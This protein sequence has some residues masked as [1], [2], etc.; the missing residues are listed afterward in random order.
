[1]L[2]H[3]T[4][5]NYALIDRLELDWNPGFTAITGET[6]AGKSIL[7]GALG[8]IVGDRA[9]TA[10]AKNKAEKVVVEA[11]FNAQGK[12]FERFFSAH[13][14][15][16]E[17]VGIVRREI[18]PSGK[19]RA[20]INDTPVKLSALK[21]LGALLVDIHGQHQTMLLRDA[22]FQLR[23][24]DHFAGNRDKAKAYA[25]V[26]AEYS[27]DKRRKAELEKAEAD[28]RAEEDFV[29]FQYNELA[30]AQL[31]DT[32]LQILEEELRTL[33]H[34][35]EIKRELYV[36]TGILSEGDTNVL[37]MLKQAESVLRSQGRYS[38]AVNNLAGR[39]TESL[40]ELTDIH[41]EIQDLGERIEV[42]P[43]R[44]QTVTER[45]DAV[46]RLLIKHRVAHVEELIA[47]RDDLESKL[48]GYGTLE[49]D[50]ESCAKKLLKLQES[51]EERAA[52]LHKTRMAHASAFKAAV[53]EILVDLGMS[54]AV[55]EVAI[56]DAEAY[57]SNGKDDVEFNFSANAGILPGPLHK[58]ASGGEMSRCMLALKTILSSKSGLP[59]II[60]D[61]IDT[62][63]SGKVASKLSK[64]LK[65]MSDGMQVICITHLPQ[66]AAR[67]DEHLRVEKREEEGISVT[68]LRV[69]TEDERVE[70]LAN[71]LSGEERS[72]AAL[73]NAK[74]LLKNN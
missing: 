71:M 22:D 24:L 27:A 70:E 30:E 28:M 52:D 64:L 61:E 68:G 1:M 56:T 42:D 65:R 58:V 47:L 8:L 5:S 45:L 62:G 2:K 16:V 63:V 43:N 57:K 18:S 38:D 34:A 39:I 37:A 41:H 74:A 11:S 26:Y 21:E 33:E 36:A 55:F 19:S 29:R 66:V 53:E 50:L 10:V 7:L 72:Q 54:K 17:P 60:F 9:D 73:D 20:F 40:I 25:D 12:V 49:S 59:C 48:T 6:G 23:V 51:L 31:E 32:D 3:F 69:L 44:L 14:L 46:N 15:D 13:D 35:E 67:A 4:V